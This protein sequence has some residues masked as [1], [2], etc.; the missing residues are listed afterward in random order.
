MLPASNKG[1][2]MN[3]GFPDV[4]L[5]PAGPAVVPIPYPNMAMNAMAAPFCPTILLTCMPALNMGSIIPMTLG[6]QPGVANP[7][8]MQMG[9]YTMGNPTITLG[10]LPG[11]NLT[12]P[13]TGNGMNNALGAVLV[14]SVTNVFFARAGTASTGAQPLE[15]LR[16]LD[17]ALSPGESAPAV[18]HAVL[19]G[20]VGY[21]AIRRF[22]S[23]VP[24]AVYHAVRELTGQGIGSLLLDLRGNPGGELGA[25]IHLAE[26]F[27][28]PGSIVV[29]V[30][31][32]DGDAMVYTAREPGPIRLPVALLVDAGTASAAELFAGSLKAN[33]RAVVVGARTYGK[34]V[35]QM[36][37]ASPQGGAVYGAVASFT[38]PD[39]SP[40]QGVG[41]DPDLPSPGGDLD[42]WRL[43]AAARLPGA[44]CDAI[45]SITAAS[46]GA[47]P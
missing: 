11:V 2:G 5:T 14:P 31:D 20:G 23:G 19:A 15:A 34:G 44:L 43:L 9:M 45:V 17:R 37:V 36:V 35:A 21:V 6:M 25:F 8:Y 27:L 47:G 4:C 30:T 1:V 40:V 26:D 42:A 16:E 41:V 32:V 33:R 13:T 28:E 24:S 46:P 38:L 18:E 10:C 22:S 12:C 7:L 29:T 39:G 3:M